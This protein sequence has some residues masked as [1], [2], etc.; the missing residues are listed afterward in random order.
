MHQRQKEPGKTT[1]KTLLD[2]W[3]RNESTSSPTPWQLQDGEDLIIIF[4]I[5]DHNF[6]MYYYS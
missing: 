3:D 5:N 4:H 2:V 6:K 1:E